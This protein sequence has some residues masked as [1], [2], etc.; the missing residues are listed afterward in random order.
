MLWN[1]LVFLLLIALLYFNLRSPDDTSPTGNPAQDD[2]SSTKVA[3]AQAQPQK[4][5]IFPFRKAAAQKTDDQTAGVQAADTD[6][7]VNAHTADVQD[8]AAGSTDDAYDV[9]SLFAQPDDKGLYPSPAASSSSS[10][11]RSSFNYRKLC[12]RLSHAEDPI[13]EL[14]DLVGDIRTREAQALHGDT[15]IDAPT[16]I[17]RFLA[18]S[19]EEAGLFSGD[20]ELPSIHVLR[21]TR[22]KL[23]YLRAGGWRIPY[24][25]KLRI[26][27]LEN[28]LNRVLFAWTYFADPLSASL[29]ECFRVNQRL[30]ASITAQLDSL[31]SLDG[32]PLPRPAQ[33]EWAV[34]TEISQGIES[35]KLP[36]RFTSQFR[37]N[38]AQGRAAFQLDMTPAEAFPYSYISP[39][40]ERIIPSTYSMRRQA[41]SD[42][43]LRLGILVAAYAFRCSQEIREVWVAG[44]IDTAMSHNCYYSV[45]FKREDFEGVDFHHLGDPAPVYERAGAHMYLEDG[46]L[47]A[48]E[49]SFSLDDE[50][51]CPAARYDKVELSQRELA[52]DVARALGCERVSD[53]GIAEN[54]HR[55]SIAQNIVRNLGTSTQDNVRTIMDIAKNSQDPDI[56]SAAERTIAQLIDGT[57][58]ED[59]AMAFQDFF[60]EGD[61]LSR[62]LARAW[63]HAMRRDWAGIVD[64]LQPE[65]SFIDDIGLYD[66]TPEVEW[67]SFSNYVQRVLYNRMFWD[68]SR[69]VC[70]VPSAYVNSHYLISAAYDELGQDDLAL[71]HAQRM[72]ELCPLSLRGNLQLTRYYEQRENIPRAIEQM[73]HYLE[74]AYDAEG[75]GIAYYR[76]AYLYWHLDNIDAAEACYRKSLGF[77]SS[78]HPMAALELTS[79]IS[80][81]ERGW[82]GMDDK[83]V[84]DILRSLGIPEAPTD[85]VGDA[86]EECAEAS[87]DAGL[88][89]VAHT[90][91]NALGSFTSDDV[92]YGVIRSIEREPD[93]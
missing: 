32:D 46:C 72:L 87:L 24:L 61:P 12:R 28:A 6:A 27:Q 71:K 63:G 86:L 30:M 80:L 50:L 67:R 38:L 69:E 74:L 29:E 52:P 2:A 89:D 82:M 19:L 16:G 81:N 43:A 45:C 1:F 76:L 92:L 75:I 34:R 58:S 41:A 48:V 66:D 62:A 91:A 37:L 68:R 31:V 4:K 39:D 23:V 15:W 26:I 40:L 44:V 65:L 78:A 22:T 51:F 33:G 18:I 35:F 42:Y 54:A 7:P 77:I 70:L 93:R 21:P 47:L 53:L 3:S 49:Q 11:H 10:E 25:A 36:F 5:S 57:L 83:R 13:Q 90:F 14:K 20:V 79:L 85:E 9:A 17:E 55:A 56:L 59:D 64:I 8:P 84:R 73:S 60:V 88:F